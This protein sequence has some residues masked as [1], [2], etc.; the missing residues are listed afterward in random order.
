[1]GPAAGRILLAV[2]HS[3]IGRLISSVDMGCMSTTGSP[4]GLSDKLS[5]RTAAPGRRAVGRDPV[6]S[7]GRQAFTVRGLP[8]GLPVLSILV[9]V[10]NEKET[11]RR[12]LDKVRRVPFGVETEIIVVDD[13]STDGTAEILRELKP[14]ADVRLCYHPDN[15]GK[16]VAVRTALDHARG[17][18]VVI[19]DADDE[20]EPVELL[21]ML[22]CVSSGRSD[23][24]YGSRFAGSNRE[25]WFT[26]TYWANRFLNGLC[27]TLNGLHLT[28][29]NTCYK[30]MRRDVAQGLD[31][32]SRGFAMEPEITTK[33]ARRDVRIVEFPVSYRPRGKKQ[34]K[35]IRA[36]DLLRYIG[37]MFRFRF[38]RDRAETATVVLPCLTESPP[39]PL[40]QADSGHS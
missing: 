37:A 16:G 18:I 3:L 13:G 9:P 8:V 2:S 40:L 38:R 14:S 27:N 5:V 28:D 6:M 36:L 31:L 30:M 12:V 25:H 11:I 21:P 29:M 35:K 4:P 33:L 7:P 26:P 23:V 20:L 17:D 10:Y 39:P 22:E 1:M 15:R 34:G 32:V 24:A 19:Q